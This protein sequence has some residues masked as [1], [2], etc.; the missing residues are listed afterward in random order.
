MNNQ[1]KY[2]LVSYYLAKFKWLLNAFKNLSY[3]Y[4][5]IF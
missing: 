2:N 4:F 5:L 1:S 3:L